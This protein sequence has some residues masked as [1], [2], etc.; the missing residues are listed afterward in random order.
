MKNFF[1][2]IFLLHCIYECHHSQPSLNDFRSFVITTEG[3]MEKYFLSA[4]GDKKVIKRSKE[5]IN[6]IMNLN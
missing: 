6:K 5:R 2:I 4:E 3:D 1:I